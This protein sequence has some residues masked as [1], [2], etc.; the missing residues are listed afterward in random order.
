MSESIRSAMVVV[1]RTAVTFA[2][3]ALGLCITT[4]Q[5]VLQRNPIIMEKLPTFDQNG[6]DPCKDLEEDQRMLIENRY[7]PLHILNSLKMLKRVYNPSKSEE[8]WHTLQQH[9]PEAP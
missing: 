9:E 3:A 5:A 8:N 2:M 6:F 4:D 1:F 7:C